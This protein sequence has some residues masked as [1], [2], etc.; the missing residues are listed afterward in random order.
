MF[1]SLRCEV[2]ASQ[3]PVLGISGLSPR[4]GTLAVSSHPDDLE[5]EPYS[6]YI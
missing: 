2:M 6:A 1:Y 3:S 5:W 4:V